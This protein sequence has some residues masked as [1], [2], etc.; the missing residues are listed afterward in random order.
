[1]KQNPETVFLQETATPQQ[2]R[3]VHFVLHTCID[4]RLKPL[5]RLEC[6]E[7]LHRGA[8]I[9][10][11][12]LICTT[13]KEK[14]RKENITVDEKEEKKRKHALIRQGKSTEI[15]LDRSM[16]DEKKK[17][18]GAKIPHPRVY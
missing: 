5:L 3:T 17:M 11:W 8:Q 14:K 13:A 6:S 9:C 10:V 4:A 1:M 18:V 12:Q 7:T 2:V 15:Q 16:F